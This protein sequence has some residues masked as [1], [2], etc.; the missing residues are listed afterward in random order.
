MWILY[1]E[2]SFVMVQFVYTYIYI[3][4]GNIEILN[5]ALVYSLIQSIHL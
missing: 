3:F 4:V 1:G 2:L 5:V